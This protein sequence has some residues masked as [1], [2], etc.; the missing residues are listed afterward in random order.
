MS[1]NKTEDFPQAG[2]GKA[3]ESRP[4]AYSLGC[5]SDSG[6][7]KFPIDGGRTT[8]ASTFSTINSESYAFGR[9]GLCRTPPES[10][11]AP[12]P[13]DGSEKNCPTDSISKD[14]HNTATATECVVLKDSDSEEDTRSGTSQNVKRKRINTPEKTL[15]DTVSEANKLC[16]TLEEIDTLILKLTGHIEKNTKREIKEIANSLA[17]RAN[18]L[19]KHESLIRIREVIEDLTIC[20]TDRTVG[21]ET[22]EPAFKSL[23]AD[24]S[25]ISG[26]NIGEPNSNETAT[27]NAETHNTH[28]VCGCVCRI[29]SDNSAWNIKPATTKEDE[30]TIRSKMN[31]ERNLESLL[32]IIDLVWPE[33]TFSSVSI[34]HNSPWEQP[35]R[36][37]LAYVMHSE[38]NQIEGKETGL[39]KSI[40]VRSPGVLEL[41]KETQDG[42]TEFLV[43]SRRMSKRVNVT[44]EKYTFLCRSGSL[45]IESQVR[46]VQGLIDTVSNNHRSIVSVVL[47]DGI[48]VDGFRKILQ[49]L[50]TQGNT[51]WNLY[52]KQRPSGSKTR[53]RIDMNKPRTEKRQT[54]ALVVG[55]KDGK[56]YKETLETVKDHLK[57]SSEVNKI[58]SIR[59]TKE[60]KL[61]MV[62]ERDDK[63]LTDIAETLKLANDIGSIRKSGNNPE[64]STM[65]IRGM[66][67]TTT[68]SEV[69]EALENMLGRS[70]IKELKLSA[71]RPARGNT[72]SI[73][74]TVGYEDA[75]RLKDSRIRIGYTSCFIEDKLYVKKCS[76][77]WSFDHESKACKSA[78]SLADACFRCGEVGHSHID[79]ERLE[80]C[81][82]CQVNGHRVGSSKCPVF[83]RALSRVRDENRTKKKPLTMQYE[84]LPIDVIHELQNAE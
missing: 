42:S 46:N 45:E 27:V 47:E 32:E 55:A 53:G 22:N 40:S 76:R 73:T 18:N 19:R 63:A 26:R 66:D 2:S 29:H 16:T 49:Y 79:C 38:P 33:A 24:Q 50:D 11:S 77:C 15:K 64:T 75:K 60:G 74:V 78:T 81:P 30:E 39:W 28:K 36:A 23:V 65:Y 52:A 84:N 59:S 1:A 58:K 25:V 62:M 9:R 48:D 71:L 41:M 4:R 13:A 6:G 68:E 35:G 82:T 34:A 17:R 51:K 8:P 12:I 14:I 44:E 69:R 21:A 56:S 37:D 7:G 83:R 72:Q 31:G 43:E 20:S 80:R 54:Y 5:P 10:S 57:D 3:A 67:A 61:L 70:E